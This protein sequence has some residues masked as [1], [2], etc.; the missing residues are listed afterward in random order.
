MSHIKH[1]NVYAYMLRCAMTRVLSVLLCIPT[2]YLYIYIV[3]M[4]LWRRLL[5]FTWHEVVMAPTYSSCHIWMSHVTRKWVMSHMNENDTYECVV[6]HMNESVQTWIRHVTHAFI[7]SH[8]YES[9]HIW[10]YLHSWLIY[11]GICTNDY[12]SN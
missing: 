2:I 3:C 1:T 4:F 8:M 5:P 7:M 6:S 12:I 11:R 10:V 9:C